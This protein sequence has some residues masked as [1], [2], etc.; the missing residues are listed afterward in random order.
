MVVVSG[1]LIRQVAADE[2]KDVIDGIIGALRRARGLLDPLEYVRTRFVKIGSIGV[3]TGKVNGNI[4][5]AKDHPDGTSTTE[6]I[7]NGVAQMYKDYRGLGFCLFKEEGYDT[8]VG[9]GTFWAY[10]SLAGTIDFNWI[11]RVDGTGW[12]WRETKTQGNN[13]IYKEP[14]MW[15]V[16]LFDSGT[17]ANQYASLVSDY[18]SSGLDND[19]DSVKDFLDEHMVTE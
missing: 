6:T 17:Y 16:P 2:R 7:T 12:L 13:A 3:E 9:L 11:N 8:P 4:G 19:L 18:W 14:F 5:T 1:Y 10:Y 15:N